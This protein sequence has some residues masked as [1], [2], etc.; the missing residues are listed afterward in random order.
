MSAAG[1]PSWLSVPRVSSLAMPR[2]LAG[3]CGTDHRTTLHNGF[4]GGRERRELVAAL[5]EHPVGLDRTFADG[6]ARLVLGRVVLQH[7]GSVA[8]CERL[9]AVLDRRFDSR[10]DVLL[11]PLP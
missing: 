10:T 6:N 7:F 1:S 8:D 2:R 5:E 4:G 9:R 3:R 11:V